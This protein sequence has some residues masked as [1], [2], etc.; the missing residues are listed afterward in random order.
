[1]VCCGGR[2]EPSS[3]LLGQEE[4]HAVLEE[5]EDAAIIG[6]DEK[7]VK[8]VHEVGEA[9]Y[10]VFAGSHAAF[11]VEIATLGSVLFRVWLEEFVVR[12]CIRGVFHGQPRFA[13]VIS[14]TKIEDGDVL[15]DLVGICFDVFP[16]EM[17]FKRCFSMIF[18]QLG[19]EHVVS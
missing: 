12:D 16:E 13:C 14:A 17:V 19:D 9:S 8:E 7:V 3:A 15:V 2:A 1:M 10:E 11:D 18:K 6:V 5:N 4:Y